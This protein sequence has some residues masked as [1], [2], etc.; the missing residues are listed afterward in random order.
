MLQHGL[1]NSPLTSTKRCMLKNVWDS[2]SI[3]WVRLES[4]GKDVVRIISNDMEIV[5][6][7][8]VMAELQGGQLQF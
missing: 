5:G 1:G 3:G 4:N 7:G 8:L 2:C 6:T